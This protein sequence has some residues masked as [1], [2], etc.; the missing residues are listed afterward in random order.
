VL[1]VDSRLRTVDQPMRMDRALQGG[2]NLYAAYCD[3]IAQLTKVLE[4]NE[5]TDMFELLQSSF[6]RR[7]IFMSAINLKHCIGYITSTRNDTRT[8]VLR[9]V[10]QLLQRELDD[11]VRDIF[12]ELQQ[13]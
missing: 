2:T 1:Y 10:T 4:L 12:N 5:D 8:H 9:T 11:L 6:V 3:I 13:Q 7:V